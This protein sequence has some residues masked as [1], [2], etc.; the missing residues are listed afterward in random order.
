[1]RGREAVVPSPL[2]VTGRLAQLQRLLLRVPGIDPGASFPTRNNR[3]F[4]RAQRPEETQVLDV[5]RMI[6]LRTT[7]RAS[8]RTR[9]ARRRTT[10]FRVHK[11]GV[12]RERA[13]KRP[14]R[15]REHENTKPQYD[16]S[17]ESS[18]SISLNRRNGPESP[19]ELSQCNDRPGR[20]WRAVPRESSTR[21]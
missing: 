13:A 1:M 18:G 9:L 10:A 3:T 7:L 14:A 16:G 4:S 11:S 17:P 19:R 12:R 20:R 8:P 15:K 21:Q 6:P 5:W 2:R